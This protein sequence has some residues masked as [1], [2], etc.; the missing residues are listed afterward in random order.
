M[1][2]DLPMMKL[3]EDHLD[4]LTEMI[5]IDSGRPRAG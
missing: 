5:N 2:K 4:S 3:N 1:I